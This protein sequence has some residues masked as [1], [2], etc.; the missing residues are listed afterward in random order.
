MKK[1]TTLITTFVVLS[2]FAAISARADL[3]WY[4]GFGYTNGF[5]QYASTNL[6][7]TNS[8]GGGGG[9]SSP[10][11]MYVNNNRLE[12]SATSSAIA[13]RQ[14]DCN[15]LLTNSSS[16]YTTS[17]QVLYASFTVICTNLPNGAGTYFASFYSTFT[18]GGG[19]LGRIHALT[20]GTVL[21]NTWRLGVSYDATL[22]NNEDAVDLAL[23]TPYQ[24]VA[25]LDP[26]SLKGVTLWVNP[27]S[28]SDPSIASHDFNSPVTGVTNTINAFAY[29]Q[30]SSFGNAFF[31]ITNLALATTFAE[32]AT[33][34]WTTNAVAPAMV[35]QPVGLTN[36]VGSSVSLSA[37]ANGQGLAS[38]TYQW[39]V[40]AAANNSNPGNVS[41]GDFSGVNANI[42]N[43]NN[44]QTGDSG[45]YTLIATTPYGLSATSSIAKVL[46][47]AAPVPPQFVTEPVSQ[48]V[49]KGL[50]VVLTTTVVSPGNVTFTWYSN[51]VVVTAGVSSAGD[52]SSL[53]LDNV[54]TNFSANYSVAATNDVAANGVVSTNAVLTVVTPPQVTIAYLRTLVDPNNNYAAT[55]TPPTI[56]YQVIGTI[57]T[58]TNVT[59]GDT[60]S[61]YLQDGTAGI[62][63]FVTGGTTIGFRPAQGDVVTVI[64]VLST[65]V[66]GLEVDVDATAS[67][68]F[69]YTSVI[70]TGV[71][72]VLPAPISIGFDIATNLDNLNY[73][74]QGAL[75][76]LKDVYFTNAG[77]TIST[78]A[79]ETITVT[80]SSGQS[81]RVEFFDLDLDTAGQTLPAYAYSVTG[82][83]YGQSTNSYY[84][85]AVTRFADINVT[86]PVPIP[87]NAIFSGGSVTFN[88]SDATFNLQSSTNVSGPY[89]TILGAS[90]GFM[91]NTTSGKTMFFRLYHP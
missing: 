56:P 25:Q 41:G 13:P 54:Q 10:N 4:D 70:D 51:N 34:V 58:Y 33:N 67:S 15:R 43:I 69:P 48:T 40:S 37:L 23:N 29:R 18:N 52:N 49:F 30:A 17:P 36:Y 72:N 82:V 1:I 16:D 62:D 32:A 75:V 53:E 14:N 2:F 6:W 89:T 73:N 64:G 68:A 11:D 24:V 8:T 9:D 85:V 39:Q 35:Y 71:T 76:K 87:L 5:V 86:A 50:T 19:Y 7:V 80:N 45:Y 38:I 83:L 27:I 78:T 77:T 26:V 22:Q 59:T 81:F 21:P 84:G 79:N 55:N 74:L 65:Y 46:I 60:S 31:Q 57:T 47:S 66:Y 20:N 12:V 91:T 42:L 90:S 3:I 44:A 63:L 88:W 28:S 61:Y